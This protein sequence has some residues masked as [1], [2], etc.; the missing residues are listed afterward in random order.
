MLTNLMVGAQ[1]CSK[2]HCEYHEL[3]LEPSAFH[4]VRTYAAADTEAG[5]SAAPEQRGGDAGGGN[6]QR[7]DTNSH[8]AAG[9][10]NT[11]PPP[12]TE[13][14]GLNLFGLGVPPVHRS[15]SDA[16]PPAPA[17]SGDAH[18]TSAGGGETERDDLLVLD[19]ARMV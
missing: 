2:T 17:G 8:G 4:A 18:E 1:Y 13:L 9:A 11:E 12:M 5:V 6:A 15:E 19:A 16:L 3:Q 14:F 7:G 10:P